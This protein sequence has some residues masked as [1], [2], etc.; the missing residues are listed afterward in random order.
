MDDTTFFESAKIER[1]DIKG[2][3]I[4]YTQFS[5]SD[6]IPTQHVTDIFADCKKRKPRARRAYL[7]EISD[8]PAPYTPRRG[9]E[10]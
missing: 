5:N 6:A 3:V 1:K 10:F 9:K 4:N 7:T 2:D 8:A